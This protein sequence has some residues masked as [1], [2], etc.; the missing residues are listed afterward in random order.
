MDLKKKRKKEI[1]LSDTRGVF[2]ITTVIVCEMNTKETI[3]LTGLSVIL[4][5]KQNGHRVN[6]GQSDSCPSG[7]LL[8]IA[9]APMFWP[10]YV[11]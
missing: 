7:S 6:M 2:L 5:H 4:P 3:S 8:A 11:Q 9:V 1:Q 10:L